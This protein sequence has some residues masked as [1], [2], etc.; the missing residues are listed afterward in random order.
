MST[1]VTSP[2]MISSARPDRPPR[3]PQSSK[4]NYNLNSSTSSS[5][6]R[7]RKS[8][9]R[10]HHHHHSSSAVTSSATTTRSSK[11]HHHHHRHHSNQPQSSTQ[12]GSE[13]ST[14]RRRESKS[15]PETDRHHHHRK[16][17]ST[18]TATAVEHRKKKKRSIPLDTIDRLDVTGLFG[19]GSFHHDGP[20][21]ACNPHRNKRVS[22]APVA[23][24][25]IDG[26][27]NTLAGIDY[28]KGGIATEN[29][30]M[31]RS[32]TEAYEDFCS[33]RDS[34]R[35]S[36]TFDPLLKANPVHGNTSLGLGTSTFLEG[37]PAPKIEEYYQA[38]KNSDEYGSPL[39]PKI[40][41][42]Q[43]LRGNSHSG[44][45]AAPL[46]QNKP[47]SPPLQQQPFSSPKSPKSRKVQ[48]QTISPARSR[49]SLE[50]SSPEVVNYDRLLPP[51][52]PSP[53]LGS[54]FMRRMKGLKMGAARK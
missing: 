11:S 42:V 4:P 13:K 48:V 44:P 3:P 2:T 20:F 21:E 37:A 34:K 40:S 31:G 15:A 29:R 43:R 16:S 46:L 26:A 38:R 30:I 8:S 32:D 41:F 6:T 19:P 52:P 23:A 24:F 1:I 25:P 18:S 22:R 51:S 5:E 10:S 45:Q 49:S 27:N 53:S 47:I 33:V 35:E 28:K 17:K 39:R 54:E 7:S 12:S 50:I 36:Q 14:H 9:T